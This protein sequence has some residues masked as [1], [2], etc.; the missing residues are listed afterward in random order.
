MVFSIW[1]GRRAAPTR[2][3]RFA[4]LQQVRAYWEGLRR[5]GQVP[6]RAAVDP[7]GIAAVLDQV[8]MA[9]RIGPGLARF[10]IAGMQINQLCG[11]EVRGL[12]LS[13]LIAPAA[14]SQFAATLERVFAQGS[15]AEIAVEAET[16]LGRPGLEGR[17]LL[18]PLAGP[19]GATDLCLGCLALEG[20][21]ARTPRRFVLRAAV[22]QATRPA[23][24]AAPAPFRPKPTLRLVP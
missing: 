5:G 1:T 10:R 9:E 12:P 19:D 22:E 14:R 20:D 2:P 11:A 17:L 4:A 8:F 15:L 7:R 16:G 18:L 6:L 23:S 3:A 24:A 21:I 13:L